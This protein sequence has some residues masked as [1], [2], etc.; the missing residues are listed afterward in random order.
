VVAAEAVMFPIAFAAGSITGRTLRADDLAGISDIYPDGGVTDSTGSISGRVTK[1]GNGVFGAH[2]VAFDLA[3]GE[4]VGNFSLTSDGAFVIARL[5]PG[6]HLVRVEPLD[7]ADVDGFFTPASKVDLDFRV[8]F[9]DRLVVV[10]RAGD[11]G[12]IEIRV[13]SK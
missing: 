11:S 5:S 6:P 4:M 8:T 1:N 2:V 12:S 13:S 10:P 7:D 9:A 3:K